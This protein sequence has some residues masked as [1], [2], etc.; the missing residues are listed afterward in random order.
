MVKSTI[1]FRMA[2]PYTFPPMEMD[3]HGLFNG[4]IQNGMCETL[5]SEPDKY[6]TVEGPTIKIYLFYLIYRR[7]V[8]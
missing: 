6:I 1:W 2:V 7:D 4:N 5:L 8:V 3:W